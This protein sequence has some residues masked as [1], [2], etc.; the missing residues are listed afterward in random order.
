[1]PQTAL[2][3]GNFDG[4]HRAHVQLVRTARTTVGDGG[5]VVVLAFDPHPAAVLR[6]ASAPSRI[7]VFSDRVRWLTEAGADRVVRLRPEPALLEVEP[8]AF[9]ERLVAEYRPRAIIEGSDFRFGRDRGGTAETLRAASPRH[10]F[11]AIIVPPVEAPLANQQLVRVSSTLVRSLLGLGR[12][13]DARRL[14]GRPHRLRSEVVPG[15]RRGRTIGVPTANLAPPE[16]MLPSDGI[17]AGTASAPDGT[18][19]RAAISVG[20]KPT[21]GD[22]PRICEVHLIGYDGPVD[23]YGWSIEVSFE[24][25]LRDQIRYAGVEPLVEQLRRDIDAAGV[26]DRILETAS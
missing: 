14:L 2:T 20:T 21:F 18:P 24:R 5:S 4:V 13:D 1:M 6:P 23:D 26:E 16:A 25:W 12:V 19:F 15:D 3:I 22:T 17:Y 8:E 7:A 10:G 11:E 9:L